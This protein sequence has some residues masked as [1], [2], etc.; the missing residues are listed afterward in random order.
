MNFNE[1]RMRSVI[2]AY[3]QSPSQDQLEHLF[4]EALYM[5]REFDRN[6]WSMR[7]FASALPSGN[8]DRQFDPNVTA[9]IIR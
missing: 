8:N 9:S 4:A 7:A 3:K 6:Q 1:N 2:N 5:A